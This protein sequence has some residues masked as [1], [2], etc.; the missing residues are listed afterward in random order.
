MARRRGVRD[1]SR[2]P[3]ALILALMFV[4]AGTSLLS[5]SGNVRAG[6]QVICSPCTPCDPNGCGGGSCTYTGPISIF[7]ELWA[8]STNFTVIFDVSTSSNL[9]V[10][11]FNFSW[12]TTTSYQFT[13]ISGLGLGNNTPEA[14]PVNFLVPSTTYYFQIAAWLYCHDSAGYH[15]YHGWFNGSLSTGN[16]SMTT[17]RG[18]VYDTAGA[19]APSGV[20]IVLSCVYPTSWSV[21]RST[22]TNSNGVYSLALPTLCQQPGLSLQVEDG[23]WEY[24]CGLQECWTSPEWKAVWNASYQFPDPQYLNIYLQTVTETWVPEIVDYTHTSEATISVT[25]GNTFTTS[26]SSS[27]A[28]NGISSSATKTTTQTIT[29]PGNVGWQE[30]LNTT[31]NIEVNAFGNRTPWVNAIQY[32]GS[33]NKNNQ[34]VSIT[35]PTTPS[36]FG[37]N[38][39]DWWDAYLPPDSP[40]RVNM[41]VSGSY[42][43]TSGIS[44]SINL[45]STVGIGDGVDFDAS[46]TVPI[47]ASDS[48][49]TSTSGTVQVQLASI[50]QETEWDICF[51][52]GGSTSSGVTVHVWL[53]SG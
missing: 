35:D 47:E 34:S 48:G 15:N 12:G 52:G 2:R 16:D 4:I 38:G 23:P 51:Q 49:T 43:I 31:G 14:V 53:L 42:N 37:K 19:H 32:W 25:S 45:G 50:D 26:S 20:P 28:G 21:S 46:V 13:A 1:V 39:C 8:N 40:D 36:T 44:A 17:V 18:I 24:L 41:S 6:S 7:H 29:N 11:I 22:T 5:T 33:P 10:G 30:L 9:P 3:A 27:I